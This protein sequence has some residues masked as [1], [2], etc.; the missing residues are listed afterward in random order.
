[1]RCVRSK[2]YHRND[3]LHIDSRSRMTEAD[4]S[5]NVMNLAMRVVRGA[6]NCRT[7]AVASAAEAARRA[8]KT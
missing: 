8:S 7:Y 6:G 1:M 4:E 2:F 3:S 5:T